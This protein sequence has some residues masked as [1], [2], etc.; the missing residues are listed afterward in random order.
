MIKMM[1]ERETESERDDNVPQIM[2]RGSCH[3]TASRA[4]ICCHWIILAQKEK[5]K[6]TFTEGSL[7]FIFILVKGTRLTA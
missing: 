2:R 4:E 7:N 1:R 5:N 3:S 6:Y